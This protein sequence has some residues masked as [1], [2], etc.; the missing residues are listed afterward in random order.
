MWKHIINHSNLKRFEHYKE[1]EFINGIQLV[2][3]AECTVPAA[4]NNNMIHMLH[5]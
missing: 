5:A 2:L 3:T 4:H 1:M